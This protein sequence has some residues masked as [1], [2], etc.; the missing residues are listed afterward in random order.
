M[1]V[2]QDFLTH[3]IEKLERALHLRKQIE[4]LNST[5]KKLFGPTPI[6]LAALQLE[7]SKRTGQRKT[8][9]RAGTNS[10]KKT[11]AA[12]LTTRK[13]SGGLSAEGRAS[14]AA[15]Q[16]ARWAKARKSKV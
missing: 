4:Q 6:S 5:L 16:K 11:G 12:S 15:A 9:G 13:K 7:L 8:S 1:S 14:I 3:P 10:R 2:L